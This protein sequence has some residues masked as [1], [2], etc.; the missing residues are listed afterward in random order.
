M[1]SPACPWKAR[2][3]S[4]PIHDTHPMKVH[5]DSFHADGGLKAED[6]W[7]DMN[8]K[9]LITRDSVNAQQTVFGI[10]VFPPGASPGAVS[11]ASGGARGTS[12]SCLPTPTTAFTTPRR[13]NEP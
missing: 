2:E 12:S 4:T 5:V 3:M 8:V 9:F 13:P 1:R 6:G 10:T 7:V 11:T